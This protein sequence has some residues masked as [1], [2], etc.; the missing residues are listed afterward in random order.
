MVFGSQSPAHLLSD[1]DNSTKAVT[2]DWVVAVSASEIA[3]DELAPHT[4]DAARA[5]FHVHGCVLLRGLLP[6]AMVEA[7][8]REFVS[9]FGSLDLAAMRDLAAKPPPN[10]L[11]QVGDARYDMTM[12][13]TGAFGRPEVFANT[14][15]LKFLRSVLGVDLH[16]NSLTTV[17]S[18]PGAPQQRVHRDY[19]QLYF[20]PGVGPELPAHAVNVAVPLIDVDLETGPT[21]VW[22][23]SHR[24]G[25]TAAPLE[26]IAVCALRRGDCMLMDYRTL[27]AGLANRSGRA[28]P[29]VYLVY[30]RPWFFDQQNQVR[31][32]RI[33]LDMS[34]DRYNELPASNRPLMTRAYYYAM[35]ARWGEVDAPA[36]AV[37]Q[38]A[39]DPPP[40]SKV[41]RND[42]CPC[43]SGK[44]FKH[45]HGSFD[46]TR[47]AS[48]SAGLPS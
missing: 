11:T 41:G 35:L 10:R 15:L 37:R 48:D 7:M 28:R 33:P 31:V 24:W 22:L 20:E 23:G 3:S 8:H 32:S 26:S 25:A 47:V 21:G 40:S 34:L 42:P 16:L 5:A 1:L 14:L 43:G 17:V 2:P 44:R 38:P 27:H 9:Q 6:P 4:Q 18:H 39:N 29:I 30:A 12:R 45:C 36:P 13:M 46:V 19:P